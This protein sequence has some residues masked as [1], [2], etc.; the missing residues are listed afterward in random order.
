MLFEAKLRENTTLSFI[1]KY[2]DLKQNTSHNSE[3]GLIPLL[4]KLPFLSMSSLFK[5]STLFASFAS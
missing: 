5:I 1:S 4:I 2:T 3:R